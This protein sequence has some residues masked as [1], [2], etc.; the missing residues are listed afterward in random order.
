[1]ASKVNIPV[2]G[3]TNKGTVVGVAIGGTVLAAYMIIHKRKTA[4]K[5]AAAAASAASAAS[6]YGYGASAGYGYGVAYDNGYYGGT[7]ASGGFAAGYYAYGTPTPAAG[8]LPIASA[9]NGQWTQA[10][11]SQLTQDGYDAQTVSAALGAYITGSPVTATQQSI[12]QQAIAIEGYPPQ[13]GAGGY[14]PSI[15]VQGTTGGGTGGGQTQ[16]AVQPAPATRPTVSA[17]PVPNVVGQRAN[18]AISTVKAAG[19][20]VTTQPWRNPLYTYIVTGQSAESAP[21]GS[22]ITLDVAQHYF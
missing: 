12:I 11:I 4:A 16:P 3:P 19:F 10:A 13:S 20:K 18:T 14:P 8:P 21:A 2:I 6:G 22:T 17:R 15:H 5:Q 9:T 1:M 7:G